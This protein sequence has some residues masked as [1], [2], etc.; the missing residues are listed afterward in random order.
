MS[1][2][3]EQAGQALRKARVEAGLTQAQ[4]A[5]RLGVNPSYV[6]NLEAGR[7][8]PTLGPR[9]RPN[10]R[11]LDR[12]DE[13]LDAVCEHILEHGVIGFSLRAAARH[14]GTTHRMLT[15]HFDSAPELV[16]LALLRIRARRGERAVAEAVPGATPLFMA[17]RSMIADE[18]AGKALLEGLGM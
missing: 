17:W 1:T 12:R 3:V 9:S 2:A 8:N 6:A 18:A 5:R 11:G 14:A 7:G 13:L 10:R 15:Y 16:R 4:V